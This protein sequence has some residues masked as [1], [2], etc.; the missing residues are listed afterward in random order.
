MQVW[1][2][3]GHLIRRPTHELDSPRL[4]CSLHAH[5]VRSKSKAAACGGARLTLSVELRLGAV[6][7]SVAVGRKGMHGMRLVAQRT[8]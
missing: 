8:N 1:C 2:G 3:F 5:A 4:G 6:A 7:S